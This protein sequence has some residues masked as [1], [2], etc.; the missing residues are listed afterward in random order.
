[1]HTCGS[2]R[3]IGS[4]SPGSSWIFTVPLNPGA[5]LLLPPVAV[6][7]LDA[8]KTRRARPVMKVRTP[9]A[10]R[11]GCLLLVSQH[12]ESGGV[13]CRRTGRQDPLHGSAGA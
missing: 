3:M 9:D 4:A 6:A 2:F 5:L 11:I 12:P 7:G 1:M 10:L 13:L 8:V